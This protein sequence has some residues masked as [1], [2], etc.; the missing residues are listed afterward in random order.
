MA[1]T[2]DQERTEQATPRRRQD[3][4]KKG[5]VA[6][7]ADVVSASVVMA[8]LLIA[9]AAFSRIGMGLADVFRRSVTAGSQ[10]DLGLI[11]PALSSGGG[12]VVTG[13]AMLIGLVGF[14]GLV[15]NFSQVGFVLS[16]QALAPKWEKLDPIKGVKRMFSARSFAEGAKATFKVAVFGWIAFDAIARDWDKFAGLMALTPLGAVGAVGGIVHGVLLRIAAVWLALAGVDYLFQ[17]KQVEKQLRMTRDELKREM[18]EMEGSPEVRAAR[19]ERRRRMSKGRLDARIAQADVVL[20]NPTHYAVAV[21]YDR[22]RMHA[23]QVIAKGQD[24][25]ALRI[26]EMAM[27]QRVPIVP[28]PPLA[29]ALYRQCEVGD[30]VPRELYQAV[31]EVLAYVYRTLKKH[32]ARAL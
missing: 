2:T 15:A 1:E 10:G 14:V 3:A 20:T 21:V 12:Q 23:P 4:R 26:R 7:S 22:S 13:L 18:K 29:R 24:Y 31:A 30:F 9:P 19:F 17:R 8:A 28:N 6:R 32:K 25:L 16:G 27:E 11:G 5:T